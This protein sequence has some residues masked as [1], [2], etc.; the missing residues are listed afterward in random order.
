MHLHL[1]LLYNNRLFFFRFLSYS[2]QAYWRPF[3][4]TI[5][6]RSRLNC[7]YEVVWYYF[8]Q[9]FPNFL[10]GQRVKGNLFKI[11]PKFHIV[12]II[13]PR[14][15]IWSWICLLDINAVRSSSRFPS[16][17]SLILLWR[18]IVYTS[19]YHPGQTYWLLVIT[20]GCV[21]SL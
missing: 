7:K 3:S 12:S 14:A 9:G 17:I 4:L 2:N 10:S 18:I 13:V 20:K 8:S 16:T 1:F 11:S 19:K 21:S 6:F 5:S 15:L